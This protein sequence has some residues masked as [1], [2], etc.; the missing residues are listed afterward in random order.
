MR[1]N[2]LKSSFGAVAGT[3]RDFLAWA[4]YG[5]AP[6]TVDDVQTVRLA[7]LEAHRQPGGGW[8]I[9]EKTP[10]D[11]AFYIAAISPLGGVMPCVEEKQMM[12]RNLDLQTV[13][14]L[15]EAVNP[16]GMAS[17]GRDPLHPARVRKL[18]AASCP[19]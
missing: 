19:Q 13:V 16:Q 8:D 1:A 12:A 10:I 9:F 15:M 4:R 14:E 18:M 6:Q 3:A 11:E 5:S 17:P 7:P 2:W